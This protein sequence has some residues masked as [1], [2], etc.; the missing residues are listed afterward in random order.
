MP[1][2]DIAAR[3]PYTESMVNRKVPPPEDVARVLRDVTERA[4]Q[5]ARAEEMFRA[6]VLAAYAN[7]PRPTYRQISDAVKA[8]G[9]EMSPDAVRAVIHGRRPSK[10]EQS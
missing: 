2:L 9:R 10:K 3:V 5:L 8:G 1:A 7:T 6:F 4:R